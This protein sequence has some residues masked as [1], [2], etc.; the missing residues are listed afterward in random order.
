[1]QSFLIKNM[2]LFGNILIDFVKQNVSVIHVLR[3]SQIVS[4]QWCENSL[5]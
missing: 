5:L 4:S 2:D 1:M 3:V